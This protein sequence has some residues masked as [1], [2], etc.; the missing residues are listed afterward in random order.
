MESRTVLLTLQSELRSELTD[1]ILPYWS[2]W[3]VDR[4]HGGFVGYI[5]GKN[6]IEDE[7][8]RGAILNARILWTFSAAYRTL[9]RD[10]YLALADRAQ[11]Y[12]ARHFIDPEFGG[13]YWAVN[14]RGRPEDDRKHLYAQAFAIYGLTEHH[15]ATGDLDSLDLARDIFTLVE[16]RAAD[17][18]RGGYLESFDRRWRLLEDQRLSETD[19]NEF[20][21][22]NT[23]LHVL[24][25]YA[26]LYRADPTEEV[27]G[28]LRHLLELF[29]GPMRNPRTGHLAP[30]HDLNWQPR[31]DAVSWGH[32]IEASWLLTD[33]ADAIEEPYLQ[34]R[35]AALSVELAEG[36]L[37]GGVDRDGGIREEM[38]DGVASSTDKEWWPQAEAVVGFLNAYQTTEDDRFLDAA[39]AC[40][41]YIKAVFLDHKGGEW[42]RRVSLAGEPYR[43]R[44]KAGPWKCPY[45]NSRAAIEIV[46]RID[47]MVHEPLAVRSG[48]AGMEEHP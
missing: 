40:W 45:H 28:R 1:R 48:A 16:D 29:V 24:E 27:R 25:A 15:M 41:Q 2:Q 37:A 20:R 42:Y 34:A 36:V 22:M 23:H 9:H 19:A 13:V 31:S 35:V 21:S 11:A 44:E 38:R 46:S 10:E 12:I 7:A 43:D 3:A 5:S 14:H 32:E 4:R 26:N 30:F 6:E 39:V 33:A 8:P 18:K 47:S 17:R